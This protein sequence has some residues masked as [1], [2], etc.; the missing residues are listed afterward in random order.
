MDP[1]PPTPLVPPWPPTISPL[2]ATTHIA[3]NE[4]PCPSPATA[5]SPKRL[6][7]NGPEAEAVAPPLKRS[8][9]RSVAS[10]VHRHAPNV[11][12]AVSAVSVL[13]RCLST[14]GPTVNSPSGCAMVASEDQTQRLDHIVARIKSRLV[15]NRQAVR[16]QSTRKAP[17]N[18]KPVSTKPHMA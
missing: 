16:P 15:A 11:D 3:A 9:T 6:F 2:H 18:H 4:V 17:R 12:A 14:P 7:A 5:S 8:N 1:A 10:S 13:D